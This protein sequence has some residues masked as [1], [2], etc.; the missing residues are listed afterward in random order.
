MR[1]ESRK[2][3]LSKDNNYERDGENVHLKEVY[4][5]VKM[6]DPYRKGSWNLAR[7]N[8]HY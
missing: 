8:L 3:S 2:V 6:L 5:R 4:R 1:K 7:E